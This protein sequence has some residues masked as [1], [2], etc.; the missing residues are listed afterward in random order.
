MEKMQSV[1]PVLRM[2]DI[3]RTRQ[4]YLEFLGF[5]VDWEHRYE[6]ELPLY[7]QISLGNVRLHLSEHYG[8][9]SPGA[10]VFI[11]ME[12]GLS[13][14]RE[15]LLAKRAGFARPHLVDESWGATTM[16]VHDPSFNRLVFSQPD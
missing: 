5:R 15:A 12:K 9:V 2:F 11:N 10:K 8:D 6:P 13:Q 1:V 3:A 14:Y 4:F 16:T 7:M